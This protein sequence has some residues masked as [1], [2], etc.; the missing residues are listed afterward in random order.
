MKIKLATLAVVAATL[1]C[2]QAN[3]GSG[4]RKRS[5]GDAVNANGLGGQNGNGIL[6]VSK[7]P[8]NVDSANSGGPLAG[9]GEQLAQMIDLGC[10]EA[11]GVTI[12]VG[13]KSEKY[14]SLGDIDPK[15][16]RP[17]SLDKDGKVIGGKDG[18][19][20]PPLPEKDPIITPEK[21]KV[22]MTVRGKF[23]PVAQANL[24]LLFVVDMSGSMGLH[25]DPLSG[26]MSN[27][28][29]PQ[30][31]G[32]CGRLRAAEAIINKV[33]SSLKEGDK[34]TVGMIP[35][36]GGVLSNRIIDFK[37]ISEF[38]ALI[39]K[40]S[41]CQYVV[42]HPSVGL[43]PVN[44]GGINGWSS[45]VDTSTNYRAALTATE[46]LLSRV[47]GRKVVYFIS[48][49]Q[50]TSGGPLSLNPRDPFQGSVAAGLEAGK[51]LRDNVKNLEVNTLLLGN[52]GDKAKDV[53][54][55]IAGSPERFRNADTAQD[56][57]AQITQFPVG[58]IDPATAKAML[59]VA[60]YPAADL[61]LAFF[62]E[63]PAQAGVW[64]YETKPFYLLGKV[65]EETLNE[66][67]VSAKGQDGSTHE[68]VVR[69]NYRQ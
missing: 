33:S 11:Q 9:S 58:Q 1:G 8:E 26:Q 25:K 22:A 39:N 42:Q 51:S 49:G 29:D 53:L 23:C 62:K 17:V 44:P 43:D 40:D 37:S 34:V 31:N 28:N 38:K 65:G 36:A 30:V 46:S 50:P 47:Y 69:I 15:V 3:F 63:D 60:P 55:Q 12:D 52:P 13:T 14:L 59:T 19:E 48:D 67:K 66:V 68:A 35:F 54:T 10:N 20:V 18:S 21:A 4:S 16:L 32:S 24:S 57:A 2:G 64:L 6:D 41:F 56:L 5:G 7:L 61:G 27:G 45:G